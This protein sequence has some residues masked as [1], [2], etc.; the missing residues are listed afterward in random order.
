MQRGLL[1]FYFIITVSSIFIFR[2]FYI[3][4]V[5][6]EYRISPLNNSAVRVNYDYP[7]RGYVF[8]RNGK[9]LAANQPS[10]DI[11]VIPREIKNLDTLELCNLIKI[12]KAT[13]IKKIEKSRIYSPYL[14]SVF[15][16]QITKDEYAYIQEKMYKFKGFYIESR[17]QREY[18]VN[19]AANVLGYISEVNDNLI[20]ENPY[21]QSGE[22]IGAQGIEKQYEEILR[23]KKGMNF[24][25]KDRFNREI[26]PY[27]DGIFDSLPEPGKDITLTIDIDLQQYG[28]KLMQ[29]KR[30]GI[31]ALDPKTGEILALISMPTYNPNLMVGKERSKNS[32]KLFGDKYNMPMYDRSLL[33]QYPPGSPF[34]IVNALIGLQ[35]GV[36]TP[37]TS[38]YCY[39]GYQYGSSAKAFMACHCGVVNFPIKLEM[40]IYKSC[41]AYFANTY[42]RTIDKYKI[43]SVGIDAWSKHLNSFGLGDFLGYDLPI[44]RKGHIPNAEYYNK[45][46]KNGNWRS[47]ATI[48]NA[49][50]QGEV[51]TTPIQLANLT[52]AIANKGFYFTPHILKKIKNIPY[53]A[54]N[55]K[56]ITTID[57]KYFDPIIEGMFQ[58]FEIGTARYSRLEA[59]QMCGK[60]GTAE[61]FKRING[62]KVQYEDHSIFIA[63]APKDNPKI[64]IAIFVE[65]GG[66][67]SAIAA[68][69]ASLMIEKY[70]TGEVLRTWMEQGMIDKS[71]EYQYQK[72]L[73]SLTSFEKATK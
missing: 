13:F 11:M 20:L 60:T 63:F 7:E 19:S 59:I 55:E 1:L 28:E 8:D 42:K 71:L 44:G 32:V 47:T 9:L 61:N 10:Y 3:Q 64:A 48:S 51:L 30:G 57:S 36:I 35:E 39:H 73:F 17:S 34:K 56:K 68:P 24:I 62:R 65:N 29:N 2:L 4:I 31:V 40:A 18:T 49:I 43:P 27:R 25:Q 70:L 46:Y 69:I 15:L 53:K 5:A 52:A 38:F 50:G 72:Q 23:G 26:G 16:S 54:Y 21:Y 33:A 66:F 58:V 41:N 67:G 14:P 37:E 22:L 6:D 45:N 12:D